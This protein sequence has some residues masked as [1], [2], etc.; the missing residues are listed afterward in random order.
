MAHFSGTLGQFDCK[1]YLEKN[2]FQQKTECVTEG[3]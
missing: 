2:V 3:K 1:Y